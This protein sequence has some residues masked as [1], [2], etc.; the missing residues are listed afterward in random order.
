MPTYTDKDGNIIKLGKII[1]KGGEG[2]VYHVTGKRN[3]VAKI[4][5]PKKLNDKK[6]KKLKV[7]CSLYDSELA[8]FAAWPKEMIYVNNKAVGFTMAKISNGQVIHKLYNPGDRKKIFPEATLG[9]LIHA[10]ANL[11][12]AVETL[13]SKG[14]VIGDINY[15]NFMVDSDAMVKLIDCDSYQV[16]YN[17]KNYVCEVGVPDYTPPELQN[18]KKF[19]EVVRTKNHDAFGLAVIIFQL[20]MTGRHPFS[21]NGAPGEIKDAIT[22]GC[23]CYGQNAKIKGIKQP[24]YMEAMFDS[25]NDT[26]KIM[27]ERAFNTAYK[28]NRPTAKDWKN[29]LK[30]QEASLTVCSK[31]HTHMYDKNNGS[32]IWCALE[33]KGWSCFIKGKPTIPKTKSKTE[34]NTSSLSS[35]RA[36]A[37][38]KAIEKIEKDF[39][40]GTNKTPKKKIPTYKEWVNNNVPYLNQALNMNFSSSG[41]NSVN[42]Q[43][44]SGSKSQAN[45][46]TQQ[47]KPKQQKPNPPNSAKTQYKQQASQNRA[48]N[49]KNTANTQKSNTYKNTYNNTYNNTN[50]TNNNAPDDTSGCV[51]C[52]V[53]LFII[54]II[55]A[56]IIGYHEEQQKLEA[57]KQ[58]RIEQQRAEQEAADIAAYKERLISA[59]DVAYKQ[60]I[61]DNFVLPMIVRLTITKDG[62]INYKNIIFSED[63]ENENES[64]MVSNAIKNIKKEPLP[65]SCRS[66]SVE[67]YVLFK[68]GGVSLYDDSEGIPEY[69]PTDTE[70]E[71]IELLK[72]TLAK[73]IKKHWQDTYIR[74]DDPY[75]HNGYAVVDATLGENGLYNFARI[76]QTDSTYSDLA[77]DLLSDNREYGDS[78]LQ[79]LKSNTVRLRFKFKNNDV[80]ITTPQEDEAAKRKQQKAQQAKQRAQAKTTPK[81]APKPAAKPVT[82]KPDLKPAPVRNDLQQS[83]DYF[84]D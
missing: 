16:T 7:L 70:E 22:A 61:K 65:E 12:I 63:G 6:I 75:F 73:K 3:I 66:E 57:E 15:G 68:A 45:K 83:S 8:E 74:Y 17:S 39:D 36:E 49:S 76:D 27:F 54:V 11:A 33:K 29:A 84:F 28:N 43:N 50:N 48:N 59:L 25:Y 9:F 67:V 37:I 41:N 55:F 79:T 80:T 18:C 60:Q 31:S 51:G 2:N 58:A 30:Q 81:P 34:N 14:V 72:R 23:Y 4:Y 77:Y 19:A 44:N 78:R 1:G 21:G 62:A 10:A 82:P 26:I 64:T 32:C 47:N 38:N 52:L 35:E 53:V 69:A 40:K 13:H 24:K 42:S 71:T 20:L 5:N 56:G 46:S